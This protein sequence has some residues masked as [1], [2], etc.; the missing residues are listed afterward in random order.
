MQH[1]NKGEGGE[2]K[3]SESEAKSM[4]FL[5]LISWFIVAALFF[6]FGHLSEA[7]WSRA[8][9]ECLYG[10]EKVYFDGDYVCKSKPL[11]TEN[12]H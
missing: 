6:Q 3:V 8:N 10:V 2:I 4:V 5:L 11:S 7:T 1:K 12:S 9:K